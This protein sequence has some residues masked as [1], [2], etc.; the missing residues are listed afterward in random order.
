MKAVYELTVLLP[1]LNEAEGLA[2]TIREAKACIAAHG[3]DAEIVVADNGSTDG[4]QAIAAA[5]GARVV[6]IAQKG[7]GYALIGGIAAARGKYIIMGDS[8]G[9]YNFSQLH[10]FLDKLRAGYAMVVGNRY[11]GG[12]E[13]GAMP[14]AHKY[15]GVP[16]LSLLARVR[17]KA[18]IGDFHCGLRGFET[19]TARHLDLRCGGMEFATEIIGKFAKAEKKMCEIT[20][21]L[22]RD[23]RTGK[24]HLRSIPDGLRHLGLILFNRVK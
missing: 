12:I 11:K 8:D 18:P 4:S 13:K 1:C 23:K 24:P 14:F 21:T 5:E 6:H 7:Y 9:S 19:E 2:F 16:M 17:Y 20:T 3:I 22:R 10:E 15:I